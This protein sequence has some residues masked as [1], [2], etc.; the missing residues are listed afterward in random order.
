M[1]EKPNEKAVGTSAKVFE[2]TIEVSEAAAKSVENQEPVKQARKY[3]KT[4]G[5][6]LTTGSADDDPSGI[7][8]YSQ[9]G[10]KYGYS[11]LW[12]APYSFVLMAVVQEIC[13]RIGL[14]TGRGLAANIRQ[15]FPKWVLYVCVILLFIAN[16][17]NIGADLGALSEVTRLFF[18]T[19][20]YI[21][22]V[23]GF[24][25]FILAMEIFFSYRKYAGY[26]K[27]LALV[28]ILYVI[29]TFFIGNIDWRTI[30]RDTIIPNLNFTKEQIFLVCGILGTTIS[31]YLFFWETSQEVEEKIADGNTEKE[32]RESK[33]GRSEIRRMRIDVWSGMF[34]SNLAMFFIITACA[35]TLNVNGITNIGT[36]AQAAEA[37]RPLAGNFSY[38]L[39]AVG[40][41]GVGLL[42]IPVLA[43]ASSYAISEAF[44]WREG[45]HYKLKQAYAFYGIIILSV[46]VGMILN[47]VGLDPIKALI[48]AAVLNGIVA[49]VMMVLIM[50][51]S[52]KTK[53]MGE[54]VNGPTTKI[55]GWIATIFMI[56]IGLATIYS[57]V[58]GL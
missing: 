8:T 41:L 4:L 39:F 25:I 15:L 33:V 21:L 44:G 27:W 23:A 17:F 45:L 10:A 35:A 14:V 22:L 11:L 12:L 29:S 40:I 6:G 47:F 49:P 55:I 48:Y 5:P 26:L 32:C 31:P 37:L 54:W 50:T 3:W 24:A 51:V 30:L 43:G 58:T 18:P 20:N 1:A 57:I 13:S 16:T 19:A 2:K 42:G 28:L 9:T 7:A 52:S 56:I 46:I 36:A 53:L 34:L 38:A